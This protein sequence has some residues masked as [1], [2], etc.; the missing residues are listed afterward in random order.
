MKQ[1]IKL[2][3]VYKESENKTFLTKEHNNNKKKKKQVGGIRFVFHFVT[4]ECI[5]FKIQFDCERETI[6]V[7][8]AIKFVIWCR[9]I[10]N[11]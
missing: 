10:T 11:K 2:C 9:F 6:H 5:C 3:V 4:V 7:K 8:S 1:I